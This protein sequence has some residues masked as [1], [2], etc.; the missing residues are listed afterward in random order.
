MREITR[1]QK[2]RLGVFLTVS[3]GL[4][5]VV[6]A[7]I[8]GANLME[9]RDNYV[10]K[11]RGTSVSGLEIGA[12]VKYNGVRVGR[13]ER[14]YIDPDTI[15]T[16]VINI[17]LEHDTPIRVD[18]KASI[19]SLSLTGLKIIELTGGTSSS[20]RLKPGSEIETVKSSFDM[21]SG[22]AEIVA[23]K[24]EMVLSNLV[25]LTSGENR[26]RI[27]ALVDNTTK[28]LNEVHG[29]LSDNREPIAIT[30]ANFETASDNI[31][32]LSESPALKRTLANLDSTTTNIQAAQ[33]GAAVIEMREAL[34][35]AKLTFMH[36]DLTLLQGRRDL[37]MSL[38][39]LRESLDSFNEFSRR[40]SEDPSLL[41][42]G[43]DEG[44]IQRGG[45]E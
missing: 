39:V 28:V 10:L 43:S 35:K 21:I 5:V 22:K 6:I 26:D 1:A 18:T 7:I 42:R 25:I 4:M 11:F 12:Q 8:T 37:L 34:E 9:R 40:I 17:S 23:E 44:E 32:E 15:E 45:R 31:R 38:E 41:L 33:I 30:I 13:V 14:I 36:V 27:L 29:I 20:P 2:V 3:I 16:V 24:L 19:S